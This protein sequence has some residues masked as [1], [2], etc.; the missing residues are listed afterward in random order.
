MG[1]AVA[2]VVVIESTQIL[3]SRHLTDGQLTVPLVSS[4]PCLF[5][6]AAA[7]V[8]LGGNIPGHL[9]SL[10]VQKFSKRSCTK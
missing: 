9:G 5:R 6:A 7:I 8:I 2:I 10:W 4:V 3:R 1:K